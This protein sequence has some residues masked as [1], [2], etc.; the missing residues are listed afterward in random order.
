MV[1]LWIAAY[2][3]VYLL[4][5]SFSQTAHPWVVPLAMTGYIAVLI[6][7]VFRTGRAHALGLCPI[8]R[9]S[10][11]EYPKLLPLLMLPVCNLLTAKTFSPT[12][13]AVV[14]MLSVCAVEEI[15]FRGF[16]LRSLLRWGALPAIV[17]SSGVFALFH[18]VNLIGGSDFAYVW[19]QVF[20]AFTVGICYGAIAIELESV[21]PCFLAHFL[22]NMTAAP[23][24]DGAVP[25]VWFC[26]TAYGCSGIYLCR[27]FVGNLHT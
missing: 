1:F 14:L 27:K 18:L 25:W 21:I 11:R 9:M 2:G 23:I 22:T 17:L 16:L 10:P 6:G 7:W 4:A 20:C 13:P 24:S 12:P 15:F 3:L 26:I 8:R 19:M 5:S